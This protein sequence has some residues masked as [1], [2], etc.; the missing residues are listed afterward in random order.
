M[1]KLH[2]GGLSP[3][4]EELRAAGRCVKHRLKASGNLGALLFP[5]DKRWRQQTGFS[6]GGWFH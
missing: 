5:A 2:E 3:C 1:N 4:H 6:I